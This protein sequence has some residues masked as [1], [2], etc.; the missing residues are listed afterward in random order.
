MI[1]LKFPVAIG[2]VA[3][4]VLGASCSSD[5]AAAPRDTTQPAH[6]SSGSG[7]LRFYGAF[8]V[9]PGADEV[10]Q[11]SSLSEAV[12]AASAVVLAT[13]T[14]VSL[15]RS[16]RDEND[17]G[18]TFLGVQLEISRLLAGSLPADR[19]KTLM[20]EMMGSA[21]ELERLNESSTD[22]AP[23]IWLLHRKGD[24]APGI[25]GDPDS[26]ERDFYRIISS[27]GVFV[28]GPNGVLNPVRD[29]SDALADDADELQP[30]A[31][32]DPVSAEA[33]QY[34]SLDALAEA[35]VG[36]SR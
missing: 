25:T 1:R 15:T 29:A 11:Y 6:A 33:Q 31:K 4:A 5:R 21:D 14:V 35:I 23:A 17:P 32:R 28:D 9:G 10:E 18:V 34:K 7:S 24:S 22:A 13:P 20:L 3:S 27:Q 36:I 26:S 2:I 8:A 16:I 19:S 30:L 12:D